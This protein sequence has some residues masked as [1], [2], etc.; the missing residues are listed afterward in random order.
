MSI[1]VTVSVPDNLASLDSEQV[2]R[3]V[4][5]QVVAKSYEAGKISLRQVRSILGLASRYEADAFIHKHGATGYTLED[6][7]REMKIMEDFG[8]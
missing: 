2:S 8:L 5:E 3:D 7:K 4:F 1:S 6:L